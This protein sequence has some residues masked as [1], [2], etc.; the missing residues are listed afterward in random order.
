MYGEPITTETEREIGEVRGP[1]LVADALGISTSVS[2]GL[3]IS[4]SVSLTVSV[5]LN[6]YLCLYLCLG[7]S[8]SVSIAVSGF[9][10]LASSSVSGF[11]FLSL[12]LTQ[13][14]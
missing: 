9:L 13:P 3:G 11:L 10:P 12:P 1:R 6:F 2:V 8:T 7:M 4:T 14:G 5:W